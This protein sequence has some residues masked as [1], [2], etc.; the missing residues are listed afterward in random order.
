MDRRKKRK[1]GVVNK[2]LSC[3]KVYKARNWLK[4]LEIW[5]VL[6][7]KKLLIPERSRVST[8]SANLAMPIPMPPYHNLLGFGG[9]GY[10]MTSNSGLALLRII[11]DLLQCCYHP[12]MAPPTSFSLPDTRLL[13]LQPFIWARYLYLAFP[14]LSFIPDQQYFS[15][16]STENIR[17]S[18][19]FECSTCV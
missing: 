9:F 16:T 5:M 15:S 2:S 7:M 13:K 1:R 12:P 11:A 4:Q 14:S 17:S 18:T 19:N 6:E 10:G 3:W 8:S